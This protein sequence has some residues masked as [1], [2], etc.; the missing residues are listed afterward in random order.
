[1]TRRPVQLMSIHNLIAVDAYLCDDRIR[2]LEE[3][4]VDISLREGVFGVLGEI[5]DL[6]GSGDGEGK[7]VGWENAAMGIC[8]RLYP[9]VKTGLDLRETIRQCQVRGKNGS[10]ERGASL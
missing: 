10:E 6:A 1:M 5:Y 3:D 9:R 7:G 8:I 2:C 4:A